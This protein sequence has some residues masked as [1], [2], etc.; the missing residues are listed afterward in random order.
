M[1]NTNQTH[2][3]PRLNPERGLRL[4]RDL[5]LALM[6]EPGDY[7]TPAPGLTLYRRHQEDAEH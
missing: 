2:H 5:L 4:L 1:N 7:P 3:T 6:P